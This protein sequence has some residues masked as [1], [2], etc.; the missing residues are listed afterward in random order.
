MVQQSR[1]FISYSRQDVSLAKSVVSHITEETGLDPWIDL[2]GI[3]SGDQFINALTNAIDQADIV[4]FLLS[5]NSINSSY[6]QREVQYAYNKQKRV[7][8]VLID[9][10]DCISGWFLF[11]F[12]VTDCID[13]FNPIERNKFFDNLRDLLGLKAP[14]QRAQIGLPDVDAEQLSVSLSVGA[15]HHLPPDELVSLY[16]NFLFCKPVNNWNVY[17]RIGSELAKN[18]Q[19]VEGGNEFAIL[20]YSR[21]FECEFESKYQNMKARAL[22]M[23]G[24][25]KRRMSDLKGA[26]QDVTIG[27]RMAEH[28]DNNKTEMELATYNLAMIAAINNDYEE[29]KRQIEILKQCCRDFMLSSYLKSIS[30]AAPEFPIN[31]V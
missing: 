23:R 10:K 9:T 11:M 19:E 28:L 4:V 5:H 3:M 15:S 1:I 18:C 26:L 7:C 22:I 13:Y 20:A 16:R 21:A 25:V 29:C 12:G 6:A 31:E 8:P 14:K 24:S 30:K 17:F 27:K 2:S